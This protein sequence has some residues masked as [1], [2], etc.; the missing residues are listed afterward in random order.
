[1]ACCLGIPLCFAFSWT[2]NRWYGNGAVGALL[3]DLVLELFLVVYYLRLLPRGLF[4]GETYGRVGRYV[5][6]A[7]PMAAFLHWGAEVGLRLWA[8][9][10]AAVIYV[11]FCVLLRAAD[12]ADIALV[13]G[14][15]SRR[16]DVTPE[17]VPGAEG[18]LSG[19]MPGVG[20]AETI[21]ADMAT[22]RPGAGSAIATK[23]EVA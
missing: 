18:P 22:A 23:A 14:I 13:R 10:P 17:P 12:R 21:A 6:A 15:L 2:G 20:P 5:I 8:V 3:S 19:T 9:P 4:G 7:V 11:A 16:P 1:V